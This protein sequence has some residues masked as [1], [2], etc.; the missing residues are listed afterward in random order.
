[1]ATQIARI[2]GTVAV[3]IPEE[4]LRQANLAVGDPVEW[5][6]TPAGTLAL[7]AP[8][9][10]SD[11]VVE[12]GYEEWARQEIEAGFAEIETGKWAS[13]EKVLEWAQSLGTDHKL[14]PPL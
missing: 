11:P 7:R 14:P 2:G 6:L 3:D 10:A 8:H 1:M 9:D 12:D 4:L 13:G 5:T